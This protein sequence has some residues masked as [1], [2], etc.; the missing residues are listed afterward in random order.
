VIHEVLLVDDEKQAYARCIGAN[1]T[2]AAKPPAP[3]P[4]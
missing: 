1:S 3:P 2:A 4:R